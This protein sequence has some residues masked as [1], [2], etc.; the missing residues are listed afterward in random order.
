MFNT[1]IKGIVLTHIFDFVIINRFF[2]IA[3][4]SKRFAKKSVHGR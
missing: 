4:L 1:Q 3:N 2:E